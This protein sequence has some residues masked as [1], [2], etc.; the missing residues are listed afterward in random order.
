MSP[1]VYIVEVVPYDPQF[2]DMYLSGWQCHCNLNYEDACRLI[3]RITMRLPNEQ[4]EKDDG[5]WINDKDQF[6][7]YDLL[8]KLVIDLPV[9][10]FL[11]FATDVF[12]YR[13]DEPFGLIKQEIIHKSNHYALEVLP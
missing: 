3:E 6:E 10:I 11:R 1:E 12:V 9:R 5:H 4:E 13:T 8:S 2:P 7:A